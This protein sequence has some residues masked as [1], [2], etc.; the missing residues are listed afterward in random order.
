MPDTLG[1]TADPADRDTGLFEGFAE[2][3]ASLFED[4]PPA[5]RTLDHTA[6]T[7]G[8][9]SYRAMTLEIDRAYEGFE[10]MALRHGW[11]ADRGAGAGAEQVTAATRAHRRGGRILGCIDLAE[12]VRAAVAA[13]TGVEPGR[14][15]LTLPEDWTAGLD[16]LP[17]YDPESR[18]L[19]AETIG[20]AHPLIGRAIG[21]V[22]QAEP[23]VSAARIAMT[24][25]PALLLTYAAD[26]HGSAGLLWQRV[27]AVRLL[28]RGPPEVLPDP[29]DWLSLATNDPDQGGTADPMLWR[30]RFA[31]WAETRL[32]EAEASV[33]ALAAR[34]AAAFRAEAADRAAR[35]T[36]D[37]AIWLRQR[38]DALCGRA[39][40]RTA[41]LFGSAPPVPDWRATAEPEQRLGLYAADPATTPE[42]RRNANGLLGVLHDRR[43][44]SQSRQAPSD[45]VLRPIGVLMLVP[46]A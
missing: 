5:I 30:R 22:R 40:P 34:L 41:D 3:Q 23:V 29:A 6:E 38:A 27:L 11:L 46:D 18:T 26:L 37:L 31:G 25:P 19:R 36:A 17:G 28:R 42:G 21:R 4:T 45:P 35:E 24:D 32:P 20:R 7:V 16:G 2:R 14:R 10:R 8:A 9:D 13:E 12:F 33:R 39:E 44:R 1:V 43:T 15:L